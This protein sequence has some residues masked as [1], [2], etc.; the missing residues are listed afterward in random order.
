MQTL[1]EYYQ[2]HR[3]WTKPKLS[4]PP[5]HYIRRQIHVTFQDDPVALHNIPLTGPDCLLWG[6]DYPHPEGI[7]PNSNK[8]LSELLK[9]VAYSDAIAVTSGNAMRLFG[10]AEDVLASQ[11]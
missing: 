9:D 5:S 3:H 7:Y 8:V 4:E 6:N 1:D 2:A 11:P 10:F